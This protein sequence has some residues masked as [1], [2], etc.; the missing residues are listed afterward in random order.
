MTARPFLIGDF[1]WCAFPESEYAATPSR[2]RHIGYV[3][4]MMVDR[5]ATASGW[6]AIVAYTTSQPW[7]FA[8][9]RP[10]VIAFPAEEAASLGQQ[11][12][13]WLHLWRIAQVPVT[14]A[15]F[16]LLDDPDRGVV[17][18]APKATQRMLDA[19]AARVFGRHGN[20]TEQVGPYAPPKP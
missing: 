5:P 7:R 12:A 6:R 19:V 17:G 18:H 1:I 2:L 10:G 9:R 16:P 8:A 14:R 4:A 20:E 11:R 3:I 13:F 15:W